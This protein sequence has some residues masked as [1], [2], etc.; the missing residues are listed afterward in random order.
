MQY[1]APLTSRSLLRL[2]GSDADSFLQN[3]ITC[4][5]ENLA[6]GAARFGALLTPQGKILFDFIIMREC[7]GFILD[8]ETEQRDALMKRLTFYKLRAD[9][10]ISV[11]DRP[12]F[13]SWF[14][15]TAQP[16]SSPPGF[17]DPRHAK[18]G[19]RHYGDVPGS[20]SDETAW[21]KNRIKLGIPQSGSDF[22]L[23]SLFPHDA[24]MDQLQDGGIDFSKGCYVGQ[25]VV[26]R[27]QHRGTARNRFVMVEASHPFP[28][29]ATGSSLTADG[30]RVGTMGSSVET[31]GLALVRVDKI[32]TAMAAGHPIKSDEAEIQLTIPDFANFG[33]SP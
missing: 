1:I 10:Q 23:G 33:W 30:K 7:D 15:A 13:A 27:M 3:L 28:P 14:D 21:H 12:V 4:D 17:A 19:W 31:T 8:I 20:N 29:G 9:V 5:V 2:E 11:D 26:S 18:L 16:Q 22:E 24:L 6:E 32:A 25:E